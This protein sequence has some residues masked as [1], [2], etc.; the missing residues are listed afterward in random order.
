MFSFIFLAV[1]VLMIMV[2]LYLLYGAVKQRAI[3]RDLSQRGERVRG[4]V[5]SSRIHTRESSNGN[6]VRT[7]IETIEFRTLTGHLVR[8][9]PR[10]NDVGL[11]DRTGQNVQVIY[12]KQNPELFAAPQDGKEPSRRPVIIN[13]VAGV[14]FVCIGAALLTAGL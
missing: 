1:S 11:T 3:L 7:L 2:G 13:A 9:R 4:T 14:F 6:D 12:S 10:S 5:V 8:A